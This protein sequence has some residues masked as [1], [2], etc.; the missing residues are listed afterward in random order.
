MLRTDR[1]KCYL[2]SLKWDLERCNFSKY[3]QNIRGYFEFENSDL[4][5][6][7]EIPIFTFYPP[8]IYNYQPIINPITLKTNGKNIY[9][10]VDIYSPLWK[11][12]LKI[13]GSVFSS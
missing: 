1:F 6:G 10:G 11:F 13:C 2:N 7:S 8:Y 9:S 5:F 3:C 12:S 4:F